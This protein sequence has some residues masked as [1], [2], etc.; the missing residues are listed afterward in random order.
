MN[1]LEDIIK[2]IK[3]LENELALE[4]HKKGD[5]FYYTIR[6]KKVYFEESI[7]KKHKD[8]A[9]NIIHYILNAS[10][11]NILSIPIILS[12][13]IPAIFMDLVVSIYHS[14]C[15]RIYGIPRVNRSDYIIIDHHK[16]NYLNFIQKINC[17]YCSYFSGL[18]GYVQEIAFR[19][20]QYW[21]PIKHSRKMAVIHS[22]CKDF[23]E[24]GDADA[25]KER[26]QNIRK[27]FD[28]LR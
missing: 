16:L 15:F 19:T 6:G 9:I 22:R 24:Y 11:L 12:C 2:K 7:K 17:I 13:L 10:L 8:F 4:M 26:Y 21:C 25:Y 1:K 14:S 18:I 3:I 28:D 5:E 23:L 27:D 20:E